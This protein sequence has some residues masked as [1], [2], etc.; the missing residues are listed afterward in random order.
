MVDETPPLRDLVQ[1]DSD[2]F[3]SFY[4]AWCYD[5]ISTLSLCLMSKMYELGAKLIV[6]FANVDITK[7]SDCCSFKIGIIRTV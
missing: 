7:I 2:L 5:P 1:N 4:S 3:L 6:Q